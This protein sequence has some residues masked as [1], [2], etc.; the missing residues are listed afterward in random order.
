[1]VLVEGKTYLLDYEQVLCIVDTITSRQLV[2]VYVG[3]VK[4]KGNIYAQDEDIVGKCFDSGDDLIRYGN[5]AYQF[6]KFWEPLILGS[7]LMQVDT[8][9]LRK[10]FRDQMLRDYHKK[11]LLYIPVICVVF[12]QIIYMLCQTLMSCPSYLDALD[13][14]LSR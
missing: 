5:P 2:C 3:L 11:C 9:S 10:V 7:L 13:T 12:Y 8:W 6:I 14:Q 1:M 4:H